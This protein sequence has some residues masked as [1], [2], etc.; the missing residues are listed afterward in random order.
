MTSEHF[1]PGQRVSVLRSSDPDH[2]EQATVASTHNGGVS[3]RYDDDQTESV[4]TGYGWVQA[5]TNSPTQK[6]T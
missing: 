3:V 1:A 2:W 6:G 4:R 5:L